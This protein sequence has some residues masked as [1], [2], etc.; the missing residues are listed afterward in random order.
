[1][2]VDV[3]YWDKDSW[4]EFF[5]EEVL[6][7]YKSA[8]T[9][10]HLW[11]ELRNRA[12]GRY[13]SEIIRDIPNLELALV[14]STSP[15]G[16]FEENSLALAFKDLL[17]ASVNLREYY[18]LRQI[19][20]EP[21]TPI[22]VKRVLPIRYADRISILLDRTLTRASE[23]GLVS[24]FELQNARESSVK[25][26]KEVLERPILI[27]EKF[28]DFLNRATSL[29]VNYSDY[30]RFIWHLRKIPK[31]YLHQFYPETKKPEV[32]KFL[33][34]LL[35]LSVFTTPRLDD[36]E[37]ADLYTI[38]SYDYAIRVSHEEIDGM[39]ISS[40]VEPLLHSPACEATRDW[41]LCKESYICS[42]ITFYFQ[43]R[44]E[45][46]GNDLPYE[47]YI[48]VG[49]ALCRINELVWGLFNM[50]SRELNLAINGKVPN[51]FAEWQKT[52][53]ETKISMS[54]NFSDCGK[55]VYKGYGEISNPP[56]SYEELSILDENTPAIL[57]GRAE[58]VKTDGKLCLIK[59]W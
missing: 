44:F 33:Q 3:R 35:G 41:D 19:G 47:P 30:V 48:T 22:E 21:K 31:R 54:L 23:L 36:S 5:R 53:G 32:F 16:K 50:C 2:S 18:F 17:G 39:N 28:A 10:V 57:V 24:Q 29:T 42:F 6:P 4:K 52:V 12:H 49:G 38:F 51:P 46:G 7:L 11:N 20:K 27:S 25:S 34:Q 26:A 15:S 58:L 14:G 43:G 55:C 13:L 9:L 8:L 59:R 1:M 45:Y 40:I 37:I 56:K